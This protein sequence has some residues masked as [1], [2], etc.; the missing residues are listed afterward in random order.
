MKARA[1]KKDITQK[2]A[3]KDKN[4]RV[5]VGEDE[6][7]KR[8]KECFQELLNVENER[9]RLEGVSQVEGLMEET[10]SEEVKRALQDMKRESKRTIRGN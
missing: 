6:T 8:R 4:G 2:A 9:G 10:T 3:I 1:R 5:L 7:K